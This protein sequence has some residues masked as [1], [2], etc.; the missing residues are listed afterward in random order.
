[1]TTFKLPDLGEGLTEAEIV[2]W[3]VTIGDRIAADQPL[4]AVETEKAVVEI[5]APSSGIVTALFGKPGEII[6]VGMPLAEIETSTAAETSTMVGILAEPAQ[7]TRAERPKQQSF[8][9]PAPSQS[10]VKAAPAIRELAHKLGV[11]LSTVSGT[12]PGSAITRD[13]VEKAAKSAPIAPAAVALPAGW[14]PLRG[15][16]RAMA[17]KMT[18]ARQSIAPATVTEEADVSSWPPDA[19]VTLL[20]VE[21]LIAAAKAEPALNAWFDDKKDARRL[22]PQIDIGIAVDTPEGLIVPVLRTGAHGSRDA[23][24]AELHKLINGARTRSLTREQMADPTITLSNF[25]HLGGLFATL[26]VVPPQVAI[27][28]VGRMRDVPPSAGGKPQRLLPLSLTFDHRAVTGGEAA[29]FL[30]KVKAEI[31]K[32]R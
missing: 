22:N 31:E 8:P 5:P 6:K 24:N 32:V 25:G 11:D 13:D 28:G 26:V 30:T 7:A 19:E 1:M 12:G 15:V 27:L 29:R 9:A 3:H 2:H 14:E 10:H 16:R 4:V 23:L 17:R 21:A 18:E 20:M